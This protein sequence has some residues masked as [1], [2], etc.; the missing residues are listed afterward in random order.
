MYWLEREPHGKFVC[1]CMA[2]FLMAE[3][4]WVDFAINMLRTFEFTVVS[5]RATGIPI[6]T[7]SFPFVLYTAAFLEE[8][9][10]RLPLTFL[11][12]M[13]LS[14]DK[15]I[16]AA[17]VSSIVFGLC[18]GGFGNIFI[19][20]VC[21]FLYSILFLKCGGYNGKYLKA[22]VVTSSTHFLYNGILVIFTVVG[23]GT[24]F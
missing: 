22:L 16:G 2:Y 14:L 13:K 10:F 24:T 11:M 18:H 21:G 4:L 15:V 8:F 1:I 20:G 9:L 6:F 5:A 12:E 7:P 3:L 23:G 17:I 19:Q